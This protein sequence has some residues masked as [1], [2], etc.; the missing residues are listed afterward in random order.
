[1]TWGDLI[2]ILWSDG[3][4]MCL[5]VKRL[6]HGRLIWPSPAEGVV[7]IPPAG[8]GCLLEDI[9]WRSPRWTWRPT[10]TG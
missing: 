1:M 7:T 10:A 8:L 9:D 3:Q 6:S 2:K 4:G 5:F